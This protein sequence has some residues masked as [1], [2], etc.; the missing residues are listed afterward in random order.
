MT[1][2]PLTDDTVSTPQIS[3]NVRDVDGALALSY[4]LLLKHLGPLTLSPLI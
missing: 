1:P 3:A 4:G 2:Q